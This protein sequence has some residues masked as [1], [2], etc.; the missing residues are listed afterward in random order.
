MRKA[1]DYS[2]GHV[3]GAINILWTDIADNVDK[4]D[5]DKKIIVYCYT[6]HT[7][8]EAQMFL[9]LMGYETYN[10]KFGMSGW[11]TDPDVGGAAGYD[12]AKVPNYATVK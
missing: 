5:P 2:K 1:E 11:N 10:M 12:P 6:G 9:N 3:E 8:G 7:A 4:I